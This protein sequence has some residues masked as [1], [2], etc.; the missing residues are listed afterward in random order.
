M[1]QK[2]CSLLGLSKKHFCNNSDGTMPSEAKREKDTHVYEIGNDGK[3]IV[4]E[5]H[6]LCQVVNNVGKQMKCTGC[7]ER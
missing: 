2:R 4:P 3:L 1:G 5:L 7:P 6:R